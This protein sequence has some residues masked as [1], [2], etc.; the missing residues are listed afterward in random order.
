MD[1]ELTTQAPPAAAAA[2]SATANANA[3]SAS[4]TE[5]KPEKAAASESKRSKNAASLNH[6]IAATGASPAPSPAPKEVIPGT[7]SFHSNPKKRKA[8]GKSAT[9][10]NNSPRSTPGPAEAV[11]RRAAA[12]PLPNNGREI[13]MMTFMKSKAKLLGGKLIAD[14]GTE[15]GVNGELLQCRTISPRA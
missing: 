14:D 6:I 2:A 4:T 13:N 15:L 9:A 3:K 1:F 10:S 11:A 12:V 5:S 8:G 7:S